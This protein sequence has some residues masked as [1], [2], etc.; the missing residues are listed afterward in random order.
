[1][2]VRETHRFA[3]G[4]KVVDGGLF[5]V[6][7]EEDIYIGL[8]QSYGG[9]GLTAVCPGPESFFSWCYASKGKG[10]DRLLDIEDWLTAVM[11]ELCIRHAFRV[12]DVAIEGYAFGSQ[13]ANMLGELGAIV[14]RFLLMEL[15]TYPLIV[16]PTQVKKFA[17]GKG[18]Q[19][20]K[21]QMLLAVYKNWNVEFHDDN[22]A[23]SFV[24]AHVAMGT[25]RFA[26]QKEVLAK[27]GP[28][29]NA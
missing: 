1:M 12:A 26:Y 7:G 9:F 17:T 28:R 22:M 25:S 14:K 16:S 20:S 15:Q 29:E 10:I 24:L 23:D 6:Q 27:L 13:R 21:S 8:D 18:T 3:H 19:V 5:N 2:P 11:R 4:A